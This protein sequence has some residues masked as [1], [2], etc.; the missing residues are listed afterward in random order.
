MWA[1]YFRPM[2][3]A[4]VAARFRL[5]EL[6]ETHDVTQAEL[7]R[8]SG[9]SQVTV[10]AIAN[11]RTTRVDLATL[12]ALS[13]ALGEIVGRAVEPGELLE[14]VPDEPTGA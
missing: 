9:V 14:R 12:N 10:N 2:P 5:A 13:R 1:P 3:L 4:P 11:N 8:R 6:L 7:V